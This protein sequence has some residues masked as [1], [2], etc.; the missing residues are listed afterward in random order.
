MAIPP[1]PPVCRDPEKLNPEFRARAAR[2]LERLKAAGTPFHYGET[3]RSVER[4]QWLFRYRKGATKCD[5]IK[6]LSRH[7]SGNAADV[8]PDG[9]KAIPPHE[10]PVWNALADAAEAEGLESGHRWGWDSPHIELVTK[11]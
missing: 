2:V 4:Q 9:F 8:Y 7:Q 10:H 11:R 3:L 5:G 6:N 1:E